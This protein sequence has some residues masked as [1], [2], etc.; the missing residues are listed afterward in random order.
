MIISSYF[1]GY[2]KSVQTQWDARL[3]KVR[4]GLGGENLSAPWT[5]LVAL[6]F[7]FGSPA[8]AQ[9][10]PCQ[11]G[12]IVFLGSDRQQARQVWMSSTDAGSFL[13]RDSQSG[14]VL[15]QWN[16]TRGGVHL[17]LLV[18]GSKPGV[19]SLVATGGSPCVVGTK[20]PDFANPSA[21]ELKRPGFL[22]AMPPGVRQRLE[23]RVRQLIVRKTAVTVASNRSSSEPGDDSGHHQGG[24]NS[25][26]GGGNQ[27]GNEGGDRPGKPDKP[28]GAT[29]LAAYLANAVAQGYY[30][31][32]NKG[33]VT[34]RPRAPACSHRIPIAPCRIG[35]VEPYWGPKAS[36]ISRVV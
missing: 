10:G 9:T 16:Q 31:S 35:Q 29:Q 3:R 24:G 2:F 15:D 30:D 7:L 21:N 13:L 17:S 5:P 20:S 6:I 18:V 26:Q 4:T 28:G 32:G 23:S 11:R 1:R 25:G 8:T 19:V 12:G 34:T 36:N 27:G 33:P 14:E 22:S